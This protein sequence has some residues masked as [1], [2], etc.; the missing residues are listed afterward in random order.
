MMKKGWAVAAVAAAVAFSGCSDRTTKKHYIEVCVSQMMSNA[1]EG[2]D[3]AKAEVMVKEI[4]TCS[5][6]TFEK[7]SDTS[8]NEVI[9]MFESGKEGHLSDRQDEERLNGAMRECTIKAMA[10]AVGRA[11]G[12]K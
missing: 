2:D 11:F 6:T 8:K 3:K 7:L 4:C 1:K 5:A 10:G 9:D 12:A